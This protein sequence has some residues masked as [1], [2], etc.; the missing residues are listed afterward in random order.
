MLEHIADFFDSL[1]QHAEAALHFGETVG[2]YLSAWDEIEPN[3]VYEYFGSTYY[4]SDLKE[5]ANK[6]IYYLG[7]YLCSKTSL[8]LVK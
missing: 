5:G 8:K 4:G 6:A 1:G 7:S 2:D 3:S